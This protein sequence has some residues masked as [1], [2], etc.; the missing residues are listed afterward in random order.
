MA[1]QASDPPAALDSRRGLAALRE[2]LARHGEPVVIPLRY[3]AASDLA[4]TLKRILSDGAG[5]QTGAALDPAYRL[6]FAVAS[7][8]EYCRLRA[9]AG[10]SPHSREAAAKR[11]RDAS[12]SFRSLRG[13]T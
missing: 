9:I 8:E 1:V 10:L 12:V 5:A 11:K 4:E 7:P 13:T 2:G 3:A 6:S